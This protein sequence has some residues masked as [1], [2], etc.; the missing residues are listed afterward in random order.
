VHAA[1][2]LKEKGRGSLE[3]I[4]LEYEER[5]GVADQA[6]DDEQADQ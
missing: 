4:A 6:E 3:S 2:R 1:T 5:G